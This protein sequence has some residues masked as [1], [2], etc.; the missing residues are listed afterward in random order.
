MGGPL[1]WGLD[2]RRLWSLWVL[3]LWVRR[4]VGDSGD[5][6]MLVLVCQ[7]AACLLVSAEL[8]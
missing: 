4:L 1:E 5:S 8:W 7:F 3:G 6:E 2:R